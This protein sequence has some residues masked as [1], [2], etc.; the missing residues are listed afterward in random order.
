MSIWKQLPKLA[1]RS[2]CAGAGRLPAS[3]PFPPRTSGEAPGP[4]S[5]AYQRRADLIPTMANTVAGYAAQR[6]RADGGDQAR[7]SATRSRW[8]PPPSPIPPNSPNSSR[9]KINCPVLGRLM[10]ISGN[11]PDLKSN[12]NFLALQS[13]A[14][15]T[16]TRIEI[17]RRDY[18]PRTGV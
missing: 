8:M 14:E 3:T 1:P 9:R 15:G 4:T 6:I 5:S 16:E 18:T 10:A 12:Q 13:Q 17:S 11:Y 2:P 7:A